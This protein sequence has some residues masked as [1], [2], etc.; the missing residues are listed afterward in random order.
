MAIEEGACAV[1][2]CISYTG[3]GG[4]LGCSFN[5]TLDKITIPFYVYLT[6]RRV[7]ISKSFAVSVLD[8]QGQSH[9]SYRKKSFVFSC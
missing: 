6:L 3:D 5:V 1:C 2:V 4:Q 9:N 8:L 7:L